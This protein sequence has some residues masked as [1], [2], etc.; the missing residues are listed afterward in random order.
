MK[1]TF[2]DRLDAL[3]KKH[4]LYRSLMEKSHTDKNGFIMYHECDSLLFSCLV[5]A[6]MN[7]HFNVEAAMDETGAWHRRPLDHGSCY[8][9][10]SGS[11][12]SRDMLLGLMFYIWRQKRLDLATD[13]FD[14]GKK[15]SWIMGKGDIAR[16]YMTPGLQSTLAEIIYR[17][18]GKNY[19]IRRN[20]PQ[21]YG[22]TN[23]YAAHLDVIHLRLREELLDKPVGK[24]LFNYHAD[25]EQMNP[26]F[27]YLAGNFNKAYS[28][29]M[30]EKYWPSDRLPTSKDRQEEWL[31]Q[32]DYSK[33]RDWIS[34]PS[35]DTKKEH[36]GGDFLFVSGLILGDYFSKFSE[37]K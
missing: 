19:F 29:L 10:R 23:G 1:N 26:L 5:N 16:I 4:N 31:V 35:H 12:I 21:L 32:R 34:S 13:L 15:N 14:Y 6:A 2:Y 22:K 37:G 9:E 11:T 20:I 33:E 8:P 36:S 25:R 7:K 18:G 28:I 17:L 3:R 30:S 27:Q 24:K